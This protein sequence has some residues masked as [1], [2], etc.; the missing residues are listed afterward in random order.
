[1]NKRKVTFL[2]LIKLIKISNPISIVGMILAFFSIL[3]I[4]PL[5]IF[6]SS[7]FVEPYENYNYDEIEKNGIEKNAKITEIKTLENTKV[8]G[9]HPILISY[10][11]KENNLTKFDKFQTMQIDFANYLKAGSDIKIKV[12]NNQSKIQYLEPFIFPFFVFYIIPFTFFIIGSI[13]IAIGFIPAWKDYKLYKSGI[14]KDGIIISLIHSPGLPITNIGECLLITYYYLSKTG[15]KIVGK[16]K[17]TD[18]LL[19]TEKK[20][21]DK[22]KIFVS[23]KDETKSCIVPKLEAQKNDWKI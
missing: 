3:F 7:N 6:L 15:I 12:Y 17:T 8:N 9:K 11:F 19:M 20:A 23:K 14:V 16:S 2:N 1:M 18:F 13:L 5:I 10:V 4:L 22:I 21:E